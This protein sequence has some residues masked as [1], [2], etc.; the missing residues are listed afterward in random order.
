M[1]AINHERLN[2]VGIMAAPLEFHTPKLPG[3]G[4]INWWK[5]IS[6]LNDIRY[7]GAICVEVEDKAFEGS[8]EDRKYSL[9]LCKRYLDQYL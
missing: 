3:L 5:F 1:Q 7:K 8:L 2:E 6:S 9:T 4:D